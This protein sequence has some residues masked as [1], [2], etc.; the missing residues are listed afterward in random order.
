MISC[1]QLPVHEI[2]LFPN[3][4]FRDPIHAMAGMKIQNC[5]E[6]L[7]GVSPCYS[8]AVFTLTILFIM[9]LVLFFPDT[10]LWYIIWEYC[11]FHLSLFHARLSIW[12]PWKDTYDPFPPERSQPIPQLDRY[13]D[14][15]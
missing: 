3:P 2:V 15:R 9:D 12:M 11:L 4:C 8:H 6:R 14:F 13:L 1:I 5:H 7:F 10:F